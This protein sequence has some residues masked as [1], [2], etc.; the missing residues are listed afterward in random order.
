LYRIIDG[1]DPNIFLVYSISRRFRRNQKGNKIGFIRTGLTG[2][3]SDSGWVKGLSGR[4]GLNG[5]DAQC[6][7]GGGPR[8]GEGQ[9][10]RGWDSAKLI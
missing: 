10:G 1:K 7:R 6:E 4:I 5:L 8:M 2:T 3:N 9:L